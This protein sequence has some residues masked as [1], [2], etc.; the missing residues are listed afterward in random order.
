MG[1]VAVRLFQGLGEGVGAQV[2]VFD[3]ALGA[4]GVALD[5]GGGGVAHHE[6][7]GLQLGQ[8]LGHVAAIAFGRGLV[9]GVDAAEAVVERHALAEQA[10]GGGPAAQQG[11]DGGLGVAPELAGRG[12]GADPGQVVGV[13]AIALA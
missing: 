6:A 5:G 8:P 4:Y 10:A 12:G 13:V 11:D 7:A 2:G 3:G 1:D 9:E